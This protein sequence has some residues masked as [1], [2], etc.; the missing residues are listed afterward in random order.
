MNMRT[1]VRALFLAAAATANAASPPS[2]QA[3]VAQWRTERV[4]ELTNDTG[5]LNLVGLFW[6]SDGPNT[7]GRAP[8]NT[9]VLDHPSLAP[10]AGTFVLANGHVTFTANSNAGIT[11]GGQPVN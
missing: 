6:L 10:T 7:F 1:V 5:W 4:A 9:L 8:S 2:E 3:S 11:H